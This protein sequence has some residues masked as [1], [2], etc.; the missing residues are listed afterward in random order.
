MLFA[1]LPGIKPYTKC[2]SERLPQIASWR[3][4]KKSVFLQ[5]KII[6]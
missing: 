3:R 2:L 4:Q 6:S 1:S 5:I